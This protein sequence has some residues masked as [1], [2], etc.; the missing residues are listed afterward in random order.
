M[1]DAAVQHE[2]VRHT[3]D[4]TTLDALAWR[5]AHISR[6]VHAPPY[7]AI[8]RHLAGQCELEPQRIGD[9]A[10]Q[11]MSEAVSLHRATLDTW[12]HLQPLSA[13]T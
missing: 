4:N 9:L 11:R 12:F 6:V 10:L 1:G 2:Q 3:R 13:P 5:N 7:H 8:A